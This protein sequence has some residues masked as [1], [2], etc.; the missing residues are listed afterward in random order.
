MF[1]LFCSIAANPFSIELG[2]APIIAEF[3]FNQ[4]QLYQIV[5]FQD[6]KL[7]EQ[8]FLFASTRS[9]YAIQLPE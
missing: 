6:V 9:R 8:L 5:G 1:L 3:V 7:T 4:R 2:S